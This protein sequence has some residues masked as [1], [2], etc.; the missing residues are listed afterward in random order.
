MIDRIVVLGATGDL[1]RRKLMPAIG[2]LLEGGHL[3][4][5]ATV[6]AI[7]RRDWDDRQYLD[8]LTGGGDARIGPRLASVLGYRVADVADAGELRTALEP[9]D[10]PLVAYLALPPALFGSTIR[11]LGTMDLPTGS[12]IV[13]EKPFGEGF[14]SARRL[15]ELLHEALPEDSIYRI[16]HFLHKQTVQNILGLRLANRILEPL[17]SRQHIERI[18]IVWD[19]V[20]GLEGRAGYYDHTGALR[21]MVQNHLLQLL[22]LIAMEPPKTLSARDLRDRKVEALRTVRQLSG[23]EVA[24]QTVRGRYTAGSVAGRQFGD[25]AAEE[26]V[27][28]ARGTETFADVVLSVDSE[29]WAGVPFRL[30]SGKALAADR[31]EITVQFRSPAPLGFGQAHD[32]ESNVLCLTMDPDRIALRLNING[33]GDPFD[34][35]AIDL[36]VD[37]AG[38]EL[39]AYARLLIDVLEGDP[40]LSIRDDE[41]EEQWRIVDPI[42]A[43]WHRGRP[44][45]L[46]YEA[47]ST[48][49]A[50]PGPR[51]DGARTG[52]AARV[53]R[54]KPATAR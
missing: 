16:D 27:D 49:P 47:G 19:E 21:D 48:G 22:A 12:R 2:S 40:V 53:R 9:L 45:L 15:N 41:A 3:P 44:P 30:R 18:D 10:A 26:D 8:W 43:A 33:P 35:E 11:A 38:H 37:L 14:D 32:P 52:G 6:T 28:A 13:V 54:G 7:G 42:L 31:R 4:A 20:L 17:W 25:Y 39:P 34:L 36:D 51:S 46:A 1:A 5:S 23:D 29:R 50:V 24:R